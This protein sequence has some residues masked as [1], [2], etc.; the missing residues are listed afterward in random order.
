MKCYYQNYDY[1]VKVKGNKVVPVYLIKQYAKTYGI[2][3]D[4]DIVL[5]IYHH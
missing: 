1:K 2:V 4:D 5:I 3:D